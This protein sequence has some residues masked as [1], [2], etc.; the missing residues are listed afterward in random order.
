MLR[1]RVRANFFQS[2][3]ISF[4]FYFAL[5]IYAHGI[6]ESAGEPFEC[7]MKNDL[8]VRL[9][10]SSADASIVVYF[11][12]SFYL[13][14]SWYLYILRSKTSDH[15]FAHQLYSLFRCREPTLE[16]SAT[17]FVTPCILQNMIYYYIGK[18]S[19]CII[20]SSVMRQAES[21]A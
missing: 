13:Q 8:R 18:K 12:R 21:I 3:F 6:N 9:K 17:H 14:K 7:A 10:G 4:D 19:L 15:I 1:K 2:N 11:Q 20:A 5:W 16:I